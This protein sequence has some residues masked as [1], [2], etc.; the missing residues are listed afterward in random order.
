MSAR[1]FF[2]LVLSL[3]V[4]QARAQTIYAV[5]SMNQLFKLDPETCSA[6][7]VADLEA[8]DIAYEQGRLYTVGSGLAVID[9]LTGKKAPVPAL[10]TIFGGN[11]LCGDGQ[12]NLYA[13]GGRISRYSIATQTTTMLV[14]ID[15]LGYASSGDLEYRDGKLFLAVTRQSDYV[16][17][18]L[19]INLEP[20]TVTVE[21]ALQA[22]SWGMAF[23]DD[24]SFYIAIGQDLFFYNQQWGEHW[25]ICPSITYGWIHGMM[26]APDDLGI[27]WDPAT[28]VE[29]VHQPGQPVTITFPPGTPARSYRLLNTIGQLVGE[30][31]LADEENT[32]DLEVFAS[33]A[34]FL[35]IEGETNTLKL[36]VP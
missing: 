33:G 5:S 30:G 10:S 6:E 31:L 25:V 35:H 34:Y 21:T 22:P 16:P 1:I 2:L 29:I 19:R 28:A 15:E 13:A 26:N 24:G 23:G 8:D 7:Y 9:P 18:L 17:L 11:A 20:L 27:N 36:L 4:Q 14:N 12:G 32:L 3:F